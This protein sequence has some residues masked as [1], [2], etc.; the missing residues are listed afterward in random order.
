MALLVVITCICFFLQMLLHHFGCYFHI[1]S[2]FSFGLYWILGPVWLS[3]HLY[4][5]F[6]YERIPWI[7]FNVLRKNLVIVRVSR[8]NVNG[9]YHLNACIVFIFLSALYSQ[10]VMWCSYVSYVYYIPS[11]LPFPIQ[12]FIVS[13]HNLLS[14]P[15]KNHVWVL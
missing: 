9:E 10:V 4:S 2:H 1:H 12:C 8:Q 13:M 11:L 14:M 3:T 7:N 6:L 5:D 15:L